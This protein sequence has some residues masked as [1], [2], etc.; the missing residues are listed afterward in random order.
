MSVANAGCWLGP[1]D[2][3]RQPSYVGY[4]GLPHS[5]AASF[6]QNRQPQEKESGGSYVI[7]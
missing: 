1:L 2:L 4:V 7:F 3:S 6:V 5:W